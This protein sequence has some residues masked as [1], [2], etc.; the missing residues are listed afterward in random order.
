MFA[1]DWDNDLL[2]AKP[3]RFLSDTTLIPAASVKVNGI[4]LSHGDIYRARACMSRASKALMYS[5]RVN[6][7]RGVM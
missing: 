6:V 4:E 1:R 2:I 7:N 5:G 3:A